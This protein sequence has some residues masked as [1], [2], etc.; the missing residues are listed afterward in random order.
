MAFGFGGGIEE[1]LSYA[2]DFRG[3]G[4][5]FSYVGRDDHCAPPSL[6]ASTKASVCSA[7]S[8]VST[9]LTFPAWCWKPALRDGIKSYRSEEH[10][11]E[12]QSP[13]DLVCRLL[14]E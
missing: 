8:P 2:C 9:G 3:Q 6:S 13:Y 7:S 1:S 12:L 11:S 14:L 4:Q 10:T 5:L